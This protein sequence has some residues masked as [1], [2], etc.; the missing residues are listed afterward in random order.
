MIVS[1][2]LSFRRKPEW[3]HW[4]TLS[5]TVWFFEFLRCVVTFTL[6]W[7]SLLSCPVTLSLIYSPSFLSPNYL[8]EGFCLLVRHGDGGFTCFF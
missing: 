6:K 8:V 5:L 1:N 2:S 3:I 7:I 4:N